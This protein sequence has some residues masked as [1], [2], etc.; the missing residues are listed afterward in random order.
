M[1]SL[2]L[3]AVLLLLLMVFVLVGGVSAQEMTGEETVPAGE[4]VV[5]E[6]LAGYSLEESDA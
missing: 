5:D 1:K 2:P 6:N 3:P 4:P